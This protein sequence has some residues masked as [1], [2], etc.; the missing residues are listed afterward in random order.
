[1]D[2][3]RIYELVYEATRAALVENEGGE[4]PWIAR[5]MEDGRVLI[6][7]NHGKVVKE[8]SVNAL[9]RKVTAVR[10]KLRVL[11]QKINNNASLGVGD[12]AEFQAQL[13]KCYG[14]LTTF[15]FLF[16]DAGER[17]RGSGS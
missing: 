5:R 16:N 9:F 7:D 3:D 2:E 8:L 15:N 13:T 1:V 4:G 6:E 12:K 10:E 14:S 11:E 17:F